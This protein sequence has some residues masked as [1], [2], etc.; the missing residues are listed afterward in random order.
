LLQ[1]LIVFLFKTY[2]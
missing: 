2:Q 1:E